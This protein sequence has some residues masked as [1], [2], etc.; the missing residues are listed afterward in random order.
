M[1]KSKNIPQLG[2]QIFQH[3]EEIE[4]QLE[5]RMEEEKEDGDE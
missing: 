4:R 5:R 1:E 3:I 2:G